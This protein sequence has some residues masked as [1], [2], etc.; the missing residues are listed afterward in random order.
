MP[1]Y[2]F[3]GGT[4]GTAKWKYQNFTDDHGLDC[5][6][7]CTVRAMQRGVI[8]DVASVSEEG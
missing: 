7:M 4:Y 3:I 6:C 5:R 8:A 1:L 2:P